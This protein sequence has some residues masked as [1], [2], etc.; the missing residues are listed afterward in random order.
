[1]KLTNLN[2]QRKGFTI[3]ELLIAM[4]VFS[5]VLLLVTVVIIGI[6]NLYSKGINLSRTQDAVRNIVG[7]ISQNLSYTSSNPIVIDI[8]TNPIKTICIGDVR[9]TY[10]LNNRI[11]DTPYVHIFWKDK[12]ATNGGCMAADLTHDNPSDVGGVTGSGTELMPSNTRL[13]KFTYTTSSPYRISATLAYGQI[14]SS[15][16]GQC[17]GNTA[18]Q[19]CAVST[20]TTT[21][22]KRL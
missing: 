19:Y 21:V 1:M 16:L 4:G 6:G 7:D 11:G 2:H 14:S 10:V 8:Q 17:L 9:Y 13:Y 3:L 18:N 12:L 22:V 5:F 15:P 20:L